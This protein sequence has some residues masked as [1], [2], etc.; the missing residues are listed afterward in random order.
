MPGQLF[1]I[2]AKHLVA[3]GNQRAVMDEALFGHT[4]ANAGLLHQSPQ[5]AFQD[6]RA[7]TAEHVVFGFAL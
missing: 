7:N 3:V 4:I 6:A 5:P 2:D 1:N